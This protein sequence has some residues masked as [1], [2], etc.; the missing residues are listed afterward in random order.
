M[1]SKF[2][3]VK[4]VIEFIVALVVLSP[5]V[6]TFFSL[7][8]NGIAKTV[9]VWLTLIIGCSG[10]VG[11]YLIGRILSK[12]KITGKEAINE[13]ITF[14]EFN[15]KDPTRSGWSIGTNVENG[16]LPQLILRPDG[17]H[18]QSLEIVPKCTYHMDKNFARTDVELNT[19]RF[20]LRPKGNYVVY[21]KIHLLSQDSSKSRDAWFAHRVGS[22]PP[23]P[24]REGTYEWSIYSKALKTEENWMIIECDLSKAVKKTFAQNGWKY[25]GVLGVRF[26]GH[27]EIAKVEVNKKR[28]F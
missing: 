3:K 21:S 13:T 6:I 17:V 5:V 27:F 23:K 26:R 15:T 22:L 14:I 4:A 11:G 2:E 25:G 28:W 19:I 12:H 1:W 24:L 20:V 8:S 7:I 16:E 9:P 18:G 10:I